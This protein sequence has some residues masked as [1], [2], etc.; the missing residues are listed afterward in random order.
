MENKLKKYDLSDELWREYEYGD[1]GHRV[2]YIINE[3][4]TLYFASTCTTHRV[5]DSKGVVHCVPSVGVNG[6]ALRWKTKPGVE[7]VAF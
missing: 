1:E 4:K 2:T 7:P 3:P 6:C 5:L